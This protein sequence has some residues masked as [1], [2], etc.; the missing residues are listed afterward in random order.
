MVLAL[1]I[2]SVNIPAYGEPF[3]TDPSLKVETFV[4]GLEYPTTMDFVDEGILVLQKNDGKV[5]LIKDGILQEEPVLDV[6]VVVSGERGLL[7]ITAMNSTVYLYFTE[8]EKDR[9]EVIGNRIYKYDWDGEKLKNSVLIMELPGS[10]LTH[11][12][13]VMVNNGKD[14]I[15]AV[16]GDQDRS[17]RL[18]NIERGEFDD[19]SV[20]FKIDV[21][22]PV[23]KP[24][25]TPS[26]TDHYYGMGI[27][28]SF[29]LA[30]DPVT[31][32]LWDTENGPSDWDEINLVNPKFNSGWRKITGPGT[33]SQI[34]K[35]PTYG[36]FE[37]SDPKFSWQR[38]VAP[39]A[40]VFLDSEFFEKYQNSV[41][42]ASVNFQVI[43]ELKLNEDR[44]G[45]V[46]TEPT[47]RDLVA[48][49]ED[50]LDDNIFG[51]GFNIVTDMKMGPDGLLYVVSM[52]DGAIYRISPVDESE[53]AL[54][55]FLFPDCSRPPQPKV[56]WAGCDFSETEII[57]ANLKFANLTNTKFAGAN[58][59]NSDLS[60]ANME[61]AN[62][63]LA[64]LENTDL[65]HA[66]LAHA[67]LSH[68]NLVNA[69]LLQSKMEDANLSYSD[70]RN[71]SLIGTKLIRTDLNDV[72][73]FKADLTRAVV[74][75]SNFKNSNL[76]Q[77]NFFSSHIENVDWTNTKFFKT[78]IPSCNGSFFQFKVMRYIVTEVQHYDLFL[79]YPLEWMA[80]AFC[81]P[82][83]YVEPSPFRQAF[84]PIDFIN[85]QLG[86]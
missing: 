21:N 13:G 78:N 55:Q 57:N 60:H 67:D 1:G 28:N 44:T 77:T 38:P 5:F 48:H 56:N 26:P 61:N 76:N 16:I 18:Q 9:G 80:N 59:E 41:L 69:K 66:N 36:Q 64:N 84:N 58:L 39:T 68:S 27:R 12:G 6:E 42:V 73:L 2:I 31:D 4:D 54:N 63:T 35:L 74:I 81:G 71:A 51:S 52:V 83:H 24:S 70:I 14:T 85:K 32:K 30:I 50:S 25:E 37:Y 62:L 11:N 23:L 22:N 19:T 46:F 65:S 33:E 3:L 82:H 10:S 86:G 20:I 34:S 45:F 53:I 79:L 49:P 75:D 43:Y 29:G 15:Y 17:G 7:G 40:I 47:L 8:S 72:N